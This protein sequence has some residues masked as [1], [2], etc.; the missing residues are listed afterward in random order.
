MIICLTPVLFALALLSPVLL[1]I[2]FSF[3]LVFMLIDIK[4]P[5][6]EETPKKKKKPAKKND[7]FKLNFTDNENL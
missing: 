2:F 6:K 7:L 3:R 1:L 5:P 4:Y